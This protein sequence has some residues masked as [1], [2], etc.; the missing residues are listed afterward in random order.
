V[1]H[2]SALLSLGADTGGSVRLP[3]AWC[4]LVGLKPSYGLLSRHGIV[5]YASSF[6]TVGILARS[7]ECTR[8][9]LDALAQRDDYSRDSTFSS[10]GPGA[11]SESSI[12]PSIIRQE[13]VISPSPNKPPS[14]VERAAR[15]WQRIW[16]KQSVFRNLS[17]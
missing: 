16:T 4:G 9:V 7:V 10:Y 15:Y 8:I 1:A 3:A 11:A 2:G 6:Y 5:S 12:A 14:G 17:H 13:E